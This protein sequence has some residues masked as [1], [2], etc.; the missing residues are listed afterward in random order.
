MIVLNTNEIIKEITIYLFYT[1]IYLKNL[2][3]TCVLKMFFI[4]ILVL[5][6]ELQYET[7]KYYIHLLSMFHITIYY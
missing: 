7:N 5:L 2:D 1:F 6:K 4:F 3:Y